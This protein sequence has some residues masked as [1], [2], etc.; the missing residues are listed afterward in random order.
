MELQDRRIRDDKVWVMH[1]LLSGFEDQVFDTTGLTPEQIK[2]LMAKKAR[3]RA[4][5]WS[6][7]FGEDDKGHKEKTP[8]AF[9]YRDFDLE[10]GKAKPRKNVI[11]LWEQYLNQLSAYNQSEHQR[12]L[13]TRMH[14]V[15]AQLGPAKRNNKFPAGENSVW[16]KLYKESREKIVI[17][18]VGGEIS[19]VRLPFNPSYVASNL[20]S[21]GV[22]F[23]VSYLV[24][25][26]SKIAIC[27]AMAGMG[28]SG[29]PVVFAAGIAAG[30]VAGV[31]TSLI[32]NHKAIGAAVDDAK[33]MDKIGAWIKASAQSVNLRQVFQ[34]AAFGFLGSTAGMVLADGLN[35]CFD[36][37]PERLQEGW[38]NFLRATGLDHGMGH[39]IDVQ[40]GQ[41]SE[42]HQQISSLQHDVS[43]LQ[44]Q[45]DAAQHPAA[46][47]PVLALPQNPV[48]DTHTDADQWPD[49]IDDPK[50]SFAEC[51]HNIQMGLSCDGNGET[52]TVAAPQI[53]PVAHTDLLN[54]DAST[55]VVAKGDNLTHLIEQHYGLKEGSKDFDKVLSEIG[56][57]NGLKGNEENWL[58]IGWKLT[59]PS[60][61]P[62]TAVAGIDRS[63]L[64]ANWRAGAVVFS[65]VPKF[66]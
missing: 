18:H 41:I 56:K 28:F 20:V 32:K 37:F 10:E 44:S 7:L 49:Y 17:P 52:V 54:S 2:I 38:E 13:I 27:S 33:G 51:K 24:R 21:F 57:A 45:L 47:A 1:S 50:G 29:A 3:L 23:G 61:D 16:G 14:Y 9:S 66:V 42:L 40:N 30:M 65:N 55:I 46:A 5:L 31:A 64:D 48:L 60:V 58:K 35:H 63:A 25:S 39:Q 15:N 12:L 4:L 11:D 59:L 26:A 34:N 19:P 36:D 53:A 8:A 22:S 43:S 62:D 6:S